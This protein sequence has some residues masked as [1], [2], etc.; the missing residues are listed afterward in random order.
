MFGLGGGEIAIIGGLVL[1]IFGPSQL[2]R[3]MRGLGESIREMRKAAKEV[4]DGE[5]DVPEADRPRG[6]RGAGG[7]GSAS[8]GGKR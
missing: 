1:L 6:D 5:A 4:T 7:A 8:E 2:P 3:L